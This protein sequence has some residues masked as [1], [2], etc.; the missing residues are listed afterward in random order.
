MSGVKKL[1]RRQCHFET[2]VVAEVLGR[3]D[4]RLERCL[5]MRTPEILSDVLS[6]GEKRRSEAR[7][8]KNRT[9]ISV[10]RREEIYCGQIPAVVVKKFSRFSRTWAGQTITTYTTAAH[11]R[12]TTDRKG[13]DASCHPGAWAGQGFVDQNGA[14]CQAVDAAHPDHSH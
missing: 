13:S 3:L 7:G 9:I 4:N 6:S 14:T 10:V 2:W 5:L 11:I 8:C 1:G 12:M